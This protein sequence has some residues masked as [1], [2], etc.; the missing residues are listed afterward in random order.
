MMR[1]EKF[2]SEKETIAQLVIDNV[3]DGIITITH[4]GI[5]ETL[6]PAAV[7]LFGYSADEVIGNNV[8]ML[9]PEP[10]HSQHDQYLENYITTGVAKII[11][12]GREVVGKRKDGT[13]FPMDLAVT[14]FEIDGKPHFIGILQDITKR[15]ETEAALRQALRDDF[16]HTVKN[17]QTLVFKFRQNAKG[18]FIYT[19]SE[20]KLAEELG[21]DSERVVGKR[22]Q[23][24]F[25]EERSEDLIQ[26]LGEAFKGHHVNYESFHG[27]RV[28]HITLSPIIENGEILEVVGSGIDITHR[29]KMEE[30]L[31]LTRDQALE[32][33]KIKSQFLANM[34]HEIRTPMNG[35]IGVSELLL[36]SELKQDQEDWVTIIHDSAHAL[37]TIINDVLDF[38]KMEAG[39]M[40]IDYVEFNLM[41]LVEGI[42]EMFVPKARKKGINLLTFVDPKIPKILIG[43]P[44]RL[45]QILINLT[46]NAIKFTNTGNVIVRVNL[47]DLDSE[48][49]TLNFTVADTGIGISKEEQVQLFQPFVQA[50]ATPTR[51][52]GGTGLGLAI[53]KRLVEL[54][55]GQIGLESEKMEG[56]TFWFQ[57]P[58]EVIEEHESQPAS[59]PT[60]SFFADL[61]ILLVVEKAV[62]R[63]ILF[64]YLESWGC[65][66]SSCENGI[67]GL[68][69]L[70]RAAASPAPIPLAIV[71][72]KDSGMD[73][74]TFAEIIK[75]DK[76]LAKTK[77]IELLDLEANPAPSKQEA[78]ELQLPQPIKHHL[79]RESILNIFNN[80]DE[81]DVDGDVSVK[82]RKTG[83]ELLKPSVSEPQTE[84]LLVE[85][86]PVNQKVTLYQ[87]KKLGYSCDVANNGY[88][89]LEKIRNHPYKL[90]LM[91][92]QMPEMDGLETTKRIRQDETTGVHIP[93]IAMTA[94]AMPK[95]KDHY[96]SQGMDDYL[97]KPVSLV[98][99]GQLL[100]K[101]LPDI[102][103]K[104]TV[105]ELTITEKDSELD[106]PIHVKN[107]ET[108]FDSNHEAITDL[109]NIFLETIP[110]KIVELKKHVANR[111]Y[112]EAAIT[113]H[114]LKGASAVIHAPIFQKMSG[115]IEQTLKTQPT[116]DQTEKLLALEAAFQ[117]IKQWIDAYKM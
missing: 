45:R 10:Y 108:T 72:L 34:S 53:T 83:K 97:S 52:Y 47:L 87:L 73:S 114:G 27:E 96:L 24:L 69:Y 48:L 1:E 77:L 56:T 107:L 94:N 101:W 81:G 86:H 85:D 91:D 8:S 68:S 105:E 50:D 25:Q 113:A 102:D 67:E 12:I 63:D 76:D 22:P 51:K 74:Q 29:K 99:L 115:E 100:R 38:S 13:M 7:Q 11:G 62:E 75:K 110:P 20:G 55:N 36:E 21:F 42:A 32:S 2:K 58:F 49:T 109:F 103:S 111:E 106:F 4:K 84:L 14:Q 5:V 9:M 35:I 26:K 66:V 30:E 116:V 16:R 59:E 39:K 43:D 93:I 19:L 40:A 80:V 98:S 61:P 88:I 18:E 112:K 3:L 33:S 17:L 46:D 6:N 28:L 60:R 54:M 95:D 90:I 78:F 31:S 70:K 44:M 64:A 57:L 71:S 117:T 79:L 104:E 37:L 92:I 23:D 65:Q 82:K 41:S 15:K 89:A